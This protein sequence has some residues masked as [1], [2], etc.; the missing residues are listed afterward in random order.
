MLSKIKVRNKKGQAAME[1]LMTY[2]W[3]ILI[4]IIAIA[5]LIAFGVLNVGRTSAN[6]CTLSAPLSCKGSS[7]SAT[8]GTGI[9]IDVYN[10]GD[11]AITVTK[12]DIVGSGGNAGQTC[13]SGVLTTEILAE[14]DEPIMNIIDCTLIEGSK[15]KGTISVSYKISPSDFVQISTGSYAQTVSA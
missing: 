11:E 8:N 7:A 10:G 15:F 3:A 4:A 12:I 9:G 5:A 14:S 13:T 2:G 1:F 6:V